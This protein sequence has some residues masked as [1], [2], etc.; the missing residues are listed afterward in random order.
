M[1]P[2]ASR[3]LTTLNSWVNTNEVLTLLVVATISGLAGWLAQVV[4][5]RRKFGW[6]VL[7]DERINL[8]HPS[9]PNPSMWQVV[10]QDGA[11]LARPVTNGSLV[12]LELRNTGWQ[13]IR[14][15]D[16]DGIDRKRDFTLRFPRRRVVHFKIRDNDRYH[17]AVAAEQIVLEP[18]KHN[19]FNLPGLQMNHRDGFQILVL[20]ESPT[21]EQLAADPAAGDEDEVRVKVEGSIQGGKFVEYNR[22]S[23]RTRVVLATAVA[24]SAVAGVIVGVTLANRALAPAPVCASGQVDIEGSTAFAPVFN[25]VVTEY[26]Q[27]CPGAHITV[28]GTGSVR[29]L[30]DLEQNQGTT[31]VIAMYDGLPEQPPDP[32][33]VQRPVG[34]IIFAVVGNRSLPANLFAVGS[35]AGLTDTQITRA[36]A[37]PHAGGLDFVPVG[38]SSVSGTRAAFVRDVLNG[39]DAAE[40][41]G[42]ACPSARGVCLEPT[43]MDLLSYVDQTP[44]AIGY[45]EADALPFFPDVGAIPVN[46]YEPTRG[47]ALDGHYTFLATEH[48]YTNGVPSGLVADLISFLT[49]QP[50]IDQLR[51]TSYIACADLGGSKLDGACSR[52]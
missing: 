50:V 20:L 29:G 43:T 24:L 47:N 44:G 9:N 17:D 45:A 32:R 49:S 21:P 48:L 13:P 16:F 36:Y 35:G 7:Y 42:G 14:K 26:E 2:E 38:R 3:I 39:N 30:T 12:V 40:Q 5:R 34:V 8:S 51:D 19:A 41:G 25:Q 1:H 28:R 10:Y 6:C 33:F 46:G 52:S 23:S 4:R 31:P 37:S 22:H 15:D 18:G 11:N 27:H